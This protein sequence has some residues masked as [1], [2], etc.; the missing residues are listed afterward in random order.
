VAPPILVSVKTLVMAASLVTMRGISVAI[1]L[2]LPP[3]KVRR[4]PIR[5]DK[6]ST[7]DEGMIAM[8]RQLARPFFAKF[9]GCDRR[10]HVRPVFRESVEESRNEHVA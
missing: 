10:L 1:G 7:S 4:R 9:Q 3:G 5:S 8:G 2:L 6:K